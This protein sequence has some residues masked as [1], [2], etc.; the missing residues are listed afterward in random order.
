MDPG[1]HAELAVTGESVCPIADAS[2]TA[3]VRS[4][5]RAAVPAGDD[6]PVEFTAEDAPEADLVGGESAAA[7]EEVFRHDDGVVYRFERPAGTETAC[8]CEAVERH[9][10]PVRHLRADDGV[11][12]LS[13]VAP[14]LDVLRAVVEDLRATHDGVSLRRLSRSATPDADGEGDLVLVDRSAFT[15]RQ[16]EVLRTAHEAGYFD[17]PKGANATEVAAELGINRSTFAEHLAAAQSRLLDA[18][19]DD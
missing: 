12:V 8:A 14:D 11:V 19:L 18:V 15:D 10:C 2:E 4:V 6:A 9:G 13:F 16:R 3:R 7:L 1:I 5:A 17:H